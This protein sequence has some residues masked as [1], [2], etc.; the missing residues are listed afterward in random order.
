MTGRPVKGGLVFPQGV[1]VGPLGISAETSPGGTGLPMVGVLVPPG[2]WEAE[3][4]GV[5]ARAVSILHADGAL[6][7]VVGAVELMEA[8]AMAHPAGFKVFAAAAA[9]VT[10][11]HEDRVSVKWDGRLLL[12]QTQSKVDAPSGR[13]DFTGVVLWDPRMETEWKEHLRSGNTQTGEARNSRGGPGFIDAPAV[14][15]VIGSINQA[16]AYARAG[17]RPAE[18]MHAAGAYQ[19]MFA[20][21][22]VEADFPANL[23]GFGPGTTPAG[24]DWLA[25]YLAALDLAVAA[26]LVDDTGVD[27]RKSGA[28]CARLRAEQVRAALAGRLERTTAAGRALL[29]GAIAGIPPGYLWE[30]SWAALRDIEA[31]GGHS[32]ITECVGR[33][34]EHGATSGEDA[35]AGF[36]A[37]LEVFIGFL[38]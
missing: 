2:P 22:A 37:G 34:L 3:V 16:I 28:A 36:T 5:S 29:L 21:L 23:V 1:V 11:D 10:G 27:C 19:T 13:L 6:V 25:G 33:A 17:G 24:D 7:S 20:R 9:R 12:C 8:R 32:R 18:G 38:S 31:G 26:L 4:V 30:L 14:K 35:L 15:T